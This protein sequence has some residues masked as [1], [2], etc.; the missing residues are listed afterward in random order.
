MDFVV[1][2][3]IW[4]AMVAT[5]VWESSSEGVRS[6]AKGK[7]GWKIGRKP[8]ILTRYHFFLFWITFPLLLSIPLVVAYS[9]ELLRTIAFGYVSGVII[10]DF[11]WFIFNK[12]WG[13]KRFG[14]RYVDWHAWI[15]LGPLKVPVLYVIGLITAA[16]IAL[17]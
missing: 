11:S 9:H 5:G 15:T 6:W 14:P 16:I 4:A 2:G 3:I 17:I 10:Q 8:W 7:T 13:L 12:R 1:I